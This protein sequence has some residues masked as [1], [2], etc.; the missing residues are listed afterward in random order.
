[1]AEKEVLQAQETKAEGMAAE[2]GMTKEE[3]LEKA[4]KDQEQQKQKKQKKSTPKKQPKEEKPKETKQ[5]KSKAK[6]VGIKDLEK[7]FNMPGKTIRRHLRKMEEN[8][9]PRGPEPYQWFAS[10]PNLKKI[11]KNLKEI[12]ER[13]PSVLK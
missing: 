4:R 6:I 2:N 7:E 11:K 10:D 1:M 9:K 12:A 3:F 5:S 8:K 13:K